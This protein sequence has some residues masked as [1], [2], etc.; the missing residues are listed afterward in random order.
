MIFD[1]L[2]SIFCKTLLNHSFSLKFRSQTAPSTLRMVP[3]VP[4]I[5]KKI[6]KKIYILIKFQYK[7][8]VSLYSTIWA[9][10]WTMGPI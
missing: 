5:E 6:E 3:E 1:F 7:V 2:A 10:N 8:S 4:W 9:M